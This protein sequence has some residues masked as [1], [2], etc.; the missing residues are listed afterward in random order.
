MPRLGQSARHTTS[1][2]VVNSFTVRP[3]DRPS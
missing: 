2:L 1:Q 3:Q